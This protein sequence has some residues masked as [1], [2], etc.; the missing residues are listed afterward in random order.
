MRKFRLNSRRSLNRIDKSLPSS[1]IYDKV[2]FV[3]QRVF[4]SPTRT[5]QN[6]FTLAYA[7]RVRAVA[8]QDLLA[9]RH[10]QIDTSPPS[11]IL[12]HCAP[13]PATLHAQALLNPL[14]PQL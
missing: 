1:G 11:S 14:D 10:P 13:S 4:R 3:R 2:A 5:F 9:L 6:E 12:S 7:R 8:D